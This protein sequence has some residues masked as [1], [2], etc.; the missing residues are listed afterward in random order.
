MDP[1][2]FPL[3]NACSSQSSFGMHTTFQW[4]LIEWTPS[5]RHRGSER[6]TKTQDIC[7]SQMPRKCSTNPRSGASRECMGFDAFHSGSIPHLSLF[8]VR[9]TSYF[10]NSTGKHVLYI[11]T[12]WLCFPSRLKLICEIWKWYYR[13]YKVRVSTLLAKKLL[14]YRKDKMLGTHHQLWFRSPWRSAYKRL[15][16]FKTHPEWSELRSFLQLCYVLSFLS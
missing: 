4:L 8:S 12:M 15:P 11:M 7:K 1:G 2:G 5:V 16:T 9:W 3:A 13:C 6:C 10:V 14:F